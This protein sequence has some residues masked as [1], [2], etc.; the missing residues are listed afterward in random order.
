MFDPFSPY[1]PTIIASLLISFPVFYFAGI[2]FTPQT[3]DPWKCITTRLA[4]GMLFLV[5]LVALVTAKGKTILLP[6]GVLFAYSFTPTPNNVF[7]VFKQLNLKESFPVLLAITIVAC[8]EFYFTDMRGG[9]F[10]QIGNWDYAN[11][12]AFGYEFCKTGIESSRFIWEWQKNRAMHHFADHWLSGIYAYYLN[13]LPYYS[14]ILLYR[15]ITEILF[16][17]CVFSIIRPYVN[18][19]W[20]WLLIVPLM[21]FP[22]NSIH[23]LSVFNKLMAQQK[24]VFVNDTLWGCAPYYLTAVAMLT[25]L[26]FISEG[27][28]NLGMLGITL[29]SALHPALT[30]ALPVALFF[31]ICI[32]LVFSNIMSAKK[33]AEL[34]SNH[35]LI[36]LLLVSSFTYLFCLIDGR[37]VAILASVLNFEFATSVVIFFLQLL[38]ASVVYMPFFTGVWF[39]A[40]LWG[41]PFFFLFHIATYFAIVTTYAV[42]YTILGGNSEQILIVYI[43]ALLIPSGTVGL[44]AG[45]LRGNFKT[46][47]ACFTM[48][49]LSVSST[50]TNYNSVLN[51]AIFSKMIQY[52]LRFDDEWMRNGK[53]EN[54]EAIKLM[55]LL[56]SDT[57]INVGMLIDFRDKSACNE[58]GYLIHHSFLRGITKGAEYFRMNVLPI[59][60]F[61]GSKDIPRKDFFNK[62]ILNHCF[63]ASTSETELTECMVKYVTPRYI[64]LDTLYPKLIINKTLKAHYPYKYTLGRFILLHK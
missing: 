58:N 40:S 9:S 14:Y 54:T 3:S 32:K 29:L 10:I 33:Q 42:I 5:Y 37:S 4:M 27:K 31:L 28:S 2:Y 52:N 53:V 39:V 47:I 51:G 61:A 16:L 20:L 7:S 22:L 60:T 23:F 48:L 41:K 45:I 30:V 44:I 63:Q 13:V 57:F 46:S 55:T 49:A 18:T 12:G 50:V 15:L 59:D 6:L 8:V 11:S 62:S 25:H 17:V 35:Q 21:L 36:L 24:G 38:V 64:I 43:T 56:S 1:H 34:L 26:I 19:T